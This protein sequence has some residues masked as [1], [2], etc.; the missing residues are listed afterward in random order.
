VSG[1]DMVVVGGEEVAVATALTAMMS[2]HQYVGP[3][4]KPIS[5][6]VVPTILEYPLT[7]QGGV[8]M[9]KYERTSSSRQCDRHFATPP[10]PAPHTE[11]TI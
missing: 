2:T 8:T 6:V 4:G 1:G 9:C 10:T 7:T 5:T 11:V 3:T